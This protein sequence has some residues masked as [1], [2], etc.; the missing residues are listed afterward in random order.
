MWGPCCRKYHM[1]L[2][3]DVYFC[4]I[5]LSIHLLRIQTGKSQ[6]KHATRSKFPSELSQKKLVVYQLLVKLLQYNAYTFFKRYSF[7][8]FFIQDVYLYSAIRTKNSQYLVQKVLYLYTNPLF[9]ENHSFA[10]PNLHYCN[11]YFLLTYF[12]KN[13]FLMYNL[14]VGH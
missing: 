3:T 12:Y 13:G 14:K 1:Y 8:L 2:I 5:L 6:N 11:N 9:L 10:L 7:D 4:H